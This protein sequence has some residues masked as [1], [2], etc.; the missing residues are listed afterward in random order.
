VLAGL[1]S[2]GVIRIDAVVMERG[3]A[4]AKALDDVLDRYRPRIVLSAPGTRARVGPLTVTVLEHGRA[5]VGG[6]WP[7]R[8]PSTS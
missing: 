4:A 8:L 3:S 1:R 6:P 2:A 5:T 7:P